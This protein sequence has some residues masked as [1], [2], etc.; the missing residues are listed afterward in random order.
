MSAG[1]VVG[2]AFGAGGRCVECLGTGALAVGGDPDG[3][4]VGGQLGG[5]AEQLRQSVIAERVGAGAGLAA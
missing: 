2:D 4:E 1:W 3:D 5:L